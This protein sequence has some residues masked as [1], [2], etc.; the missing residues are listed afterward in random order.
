MDVERNLFFEKNFME[1]EDHLPTVECVCRYSLDVIVGEDERLQSAQDRKLCYPEDVVV[2]KI[3]ALIVIPCYA[4]ILEHL[5]V[6]SGELEGQNSTYD[7]GSAFYRGGA[8]KNK[9]HFIKSLF[10]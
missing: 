1:V 4:Q 6:I 10:L 5:D 9:S 8:K 2:G 7:W 3:E